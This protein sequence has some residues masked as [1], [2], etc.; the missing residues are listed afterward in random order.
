MADEGSADVAV[1]LALKTVS[2]RDDDVGARFRLATVLV[3]DVGICTALDVCAGL[4]SGGLGGAVL[5]GAVVV[6]DLG[7]AVGGMD[8]VAWSDMVALNFPTS[9]ATHFSILSS[10]MLILGR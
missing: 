6:V 1:H 4:R 8:G 9:G 5:G 7:R 3:G 10:S 2:G